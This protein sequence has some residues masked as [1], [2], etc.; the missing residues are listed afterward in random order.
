[1]IRKPDIVARYILK[2]VLPDFDSYYLQGDYEEEFNDIYERKGA[3]SAHLWFWYLVLESLPGFIS[4]SVNRS[5]NMIKNYLKITI[6]T[7]FKNKG[8]SFI[9]IAGLSL[10]MSVCLMIIVFV[11]HETSSDN[12]HENKDRIF[13]IYTTDNDIQYSEIKGWATTP[14]PLGSQLL[15][16]YGGI[17]DVVQIRRLWSANVLHE[18]TAFP[19]DGFL[20]GPSFFNL[21]SYNLSTGNPET[22]L[23]EPNTI[24]LSQEMAD[25]FFLGIDP[26]GKTITLETFGEFRVT[27]VLENMKVKSHF[28]FDF[29]ISL[30]TA[31]SLEARQIFSP[32]ITSWSNVYNYYTYILL[33]DQEYAETLAADLPGLESRVFTNEQNERLGFGIQHLLDI[34]LGINLGSF[35]PGTKHSFEII[36]IPFVA[37][38]IILLAC[39]NYIILSIARALKRT[40][41]I[42]LRKVVGSVR[43][44]IVILF[45]SE[46]FIITIASLVGACLIMLILVPVFNQMELIVYANSQINLELLR[47]PSIYAVFLIFA[48]AVS[49]I[50]GLYPAMYLSSFRPVNALQGV[51]RVKGTS[52]FRTRKFMMVT[53]FMVSIVAIIVITFI[54][55]QYRYMLTYD[56]GIEIENKVNIRLGDVKSETLKSMVLTNSDVHGVSVCSNIPIHGAWGR[57]YLKNMDMAEPLLIA[58]FSADPDFLE[59][60]GL[61]LAAGRNF[62]DEY[63]T[64]KTHGIILNEKALEVF[65]LGTP[66][67]ALDKHVYSN[68]NKQY[69]IIGIVKDFNYRNLENPIEAMA[70]RYSPETW[71]YATI[72][73]APGKK[74]EIRNYLGELWEELDPVHRIDCSFYDDMEREQS[75]FIQGVLAIASWGTGL[76]ILIALLG[77]L[78]MTMYSMEL[79]LKEVGIRK[80]MGASVQR[81]VYMLSRD[82]LKLIM[83]AGIIG[84]PLAWFISGAFLQIFAFRTELSFWI[85]PLAFLFITFLALMTIGTQTLKAASSDIVNTLREE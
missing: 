2:W 51:S 55:K 24:I 39:F 64:D 82:S 44:Q 9:N 12:F 38:L 3:L 5:L 29:L 37:F 80:V 83:I 81:I 72:S 21:F 68:K 28:E 54:S 61:E 48:I 66:D 41:E 23:K 11:K 42:G 45:L 52:S 76:I 13:R 6:R 16:D 78:G 8:F 57:T 77:L 67:E 26:V 74:A 46:A 85:F 18:K 73:Y 31:S 36:F 49:L 30:S 4:R 75:D 14:E 15:A 27:G 60:F 79:R 19:V 56:K 1:M 32:A 71:E 65:E 33:V 70:I 53:Q 84:C 10:S 62:S 34:N 35:M 20:T 50:A 22:A 69:N 40:R 59:N 47:D 63:S 7:I 25:K 58:Y 17:E 43:S